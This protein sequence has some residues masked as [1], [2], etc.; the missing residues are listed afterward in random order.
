LRCFFNSIT[1]FIVSSKDLVFLVSAK[2]AM[3]DRQAL[4]QFLVV[5]L[6]VR[7]ANVLGCVG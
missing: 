2:S 4:L 5:S 1:P 3:A 7:I 6:H